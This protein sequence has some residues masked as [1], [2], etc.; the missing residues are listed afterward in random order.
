MF[1]KIKV[2]QFIKYATPTKTAGDPLVGRDPPVWEPLL[3]IVSHRII[4]KSY[5]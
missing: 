3:Y 2:Y 4:H 5:Y 1:I